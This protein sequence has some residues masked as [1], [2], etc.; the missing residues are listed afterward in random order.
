MDPTHPCRPWPALLVIMA[1]IGSA[2][3]APA[4]AIARTFELRPRDGLGAQFEAGYRRH[5]DWHLAAGDRK[6]WYLWEV[7]DGERAGLVVD[8]T[9]GHAWAAFDA[10]VDFA[11]DAADNA[12]NVEPFVVRGA[13]HAWRRRPDLEPAAAA[14]AG[15]PERGAYVVRTEYRVRPG[16]LAAF[17]AALGTLRAAAGERPFAVFELVTGGAPS[18][19]V[20]WVPAATWAGAG[21]FSD[22]T[23]ATGAA[24]A[25]A[26][27]WARAEHWRF[28]PDLST[29]VDAATGCY[30]TVP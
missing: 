3:D 19:W 22:R 1:L 28:R 10:A 11:G 25:G 12:L 29:C 8:G 23:A 15:I 7:M 20:T 4:Q 24:L 5:L 9:F 16:A 18:T 27:E 21:A 13:N 2:A 30:R 6:A 14:G 26:A 17:L